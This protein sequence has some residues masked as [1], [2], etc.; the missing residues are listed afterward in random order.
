MVAYHLQPN[1]L[2]DEHDDDELD[3][4]E[5]EDDE[6]HEE[7]EDEEHEE[8]DDDEQDELERDE[9]EELSDEEQLFRRWADRFRRCTFLL[10]FE[11]WFLDELELEEEL[12]LRE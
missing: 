4:H 3:E 9:H 8:L 11:W 5:L 10:L 6:E 2:D 12:E 7:L 1:D